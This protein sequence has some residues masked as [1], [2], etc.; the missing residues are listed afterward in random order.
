MDKQNQNDLI[1]AAEHIYKT[2]DEALG[3]KDHE[4][5]LALYA[6][7][8]SIESPPLFSFW[9]SNAASARGTTSCAALS[10]WFSSDSRRSASAIAADSLPMERNSCGSIL[11]RRQGGEQMDFVEVMELKE[12][13]IHRQRVYWGWFGLSILTRNQH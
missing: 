1:A 8:A 13:L 5:A 4:A 11:G 7:D 12:G 10:V 3:A 6:A 2:W 9:G